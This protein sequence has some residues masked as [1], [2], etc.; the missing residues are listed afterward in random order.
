[1]LLAI[2]IGRMCSLTW[3]QV[4]FVTLFL[5]VEKKVVPGEKAKALV[6]HVDALTSKVYVSLREEL[7]KQ[8]AKQVC[9][10]FGFMCFCSSSKPD[11]H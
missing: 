9:L 10:Q 1:M 4:D 8:K 6:L 7:L 11:D 2:N 5:F 3:Y